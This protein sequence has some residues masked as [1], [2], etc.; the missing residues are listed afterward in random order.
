MQAFAAR[1]DHTVV[2]AVRKLG[3]TPDVPTAQGSKVVEIKYD[4]AVLSDAGDAIAMLQREHGISS[5]DIVH[6]RQLAWTAPL[7]WWPRTGY[8]DMGQVIANAGI[9]V[10]YNPVAEVPLDQAEES[11]RV[12][13]SHVTPWHWP[14]GHLAQLIIDLIHLGSRPSGAFPSMQASPGEGRQVYLHFVRD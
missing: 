9:M 11:L 3:S 10:D 7:L 6:K 4:A 8:A 2:A 12:N 13:V 14:P 5:I 1:P